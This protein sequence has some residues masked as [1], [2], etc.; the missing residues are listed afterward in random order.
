MSQQCLG[1]DKK[2]GATVPC[3]QNNNGFFRYCWDHLGLVVGLEKKEHAPS[4]YGPK[5]ML[6]TTRK[7]RRGETLLEYIGS[8]KNFPAWV[9]WAPV[10]FTFDNND[11]D[12]G[13]T[14]KKVRCVL[15][16]TKCA[17]NDPPCDRRVVISH[18]YCT[19]HLRTYYNLE[20][21]K[22]TIQSAG[23]GLFACKA[24]GTDSE[25]VFKKGDVV[26]YYFGEVTTQQE[27]E[28]K[29]GASTAPYS[30]ATDVT[31]Q[32]GEIVVDAACKRGYAAYI[33]HADDKS[34]NSQFNV[35]DYNDGVN[36]PRL[37]VEARRDIY[38]EEEIFASYGQEYNLNEE[39]TV[40]T[41]VFH[42]HTGRTSTR[43]PNDELLDL[44]NANATIIRGADGMFYLKAL[45]DLKEGTRLRITY[46][47]TETT[48]RFLYH[49]SEELV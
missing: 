26:A 12:D 20:I 30:M 34:A 49:A 10:V 4:H 44:S 15:Q 19:E 46:A 43:S 25:I 41:R 35:H 42:I 36:Y 40:S 7:R 5:P 13:T 39:N 2:G 6:K 18:N 28:R 17:F 31:G 38:H 33:N 9:D 11:G 16:E 47:H 48:P 24:R 3:S 37:W 21:K 8:T 27:L 45:D 1:V 32:R 14:R 29:Y 22:S 23:L